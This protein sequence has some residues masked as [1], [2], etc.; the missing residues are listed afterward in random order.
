MT[1]DKHNIFKSA[2]QN[3][4]KEEPQ[5][6]HNGQ[7]TK[8]Q[9]VESLKSEI[10]ELIQDGY[11]TKQIADQLNNIEGFEISDKVLSSYLSRI[12]KANGTMRRI[13]NGHKEPN[14]MNF[15]SSQNINDN[16]DSNNESINKE[17]NKELKPVDSEIDWD[18]KPPVA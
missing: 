8:F 11:S 18:Q 5:K 15:P 16:H 1:D 3:L 10:D 9:R 7:L 13:R 6:K 14:S 17:N 4:K 2:L 12:N